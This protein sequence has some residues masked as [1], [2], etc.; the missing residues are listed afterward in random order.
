MEAT[1]R[2]S[3]A[4][5]WQRAFVETE[6]TK[7]REKKRDKN[8]E[9][10]SCTQCAHFSRLIELSKRLSFRS[11]I[12]FDARFTSHLAVLQ[13]HPKW[14][15]LIAATFKCANATEKKILGVKGRRLVCSNSVIINK[16]Q[17]KGKKDFFNPFLSPPKPFLIKRHT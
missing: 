8:A 10:K 2:V 12:P 15:S 5:E 14:R 9:W 13:L 17:K 16:R 11:L 3:E 4:I 6:D 7:L 1:C